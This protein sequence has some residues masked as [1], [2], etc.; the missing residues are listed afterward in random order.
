MNP[1]VYIKEGSY[2]IGTVGHVAEG[3]GGYLFHRGKALDCIPSCEY[4]T[5]PHIEAE[6]YVD[7]KNLIYVRGRNEREGD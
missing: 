6:I 2:P 1:D 7:K 5:F 3:W 4:V